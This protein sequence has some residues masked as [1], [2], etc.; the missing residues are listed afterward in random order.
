MP[1]RTILALAF[2][3]GLTIAGSADAAASTYHSCP[4]VRNS[5]AGIH[6]IKVR[7]TSCRTAK[8]VLTHENDHP[9]W[10]CDKRPATRTGFPVV[11]SG[12]NGKVIRAE[13]GD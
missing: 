4:S 3:V 5:G 13:Y 11:C 10:T 2:A 6:S 1:R 9:G 8:Y 7:R 12:H